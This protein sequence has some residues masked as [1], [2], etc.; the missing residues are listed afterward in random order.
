MKKMGDVFDEY[1][2]T[3]ENDDNPK[4]EKEKII[5]NKNKTVLKQ[6]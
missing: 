1:T 5:I 4:T 3:Q 2:K 6:N